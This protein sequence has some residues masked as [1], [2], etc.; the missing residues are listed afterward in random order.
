MRFLARIS[1]TGMAGSALSTRLLLVAVAL[2]G[3]AHIAVLP[4]W[5]GFD[6]FA[7]WSSIQQIADT[8]TV[9]FHGRARISAE[10]EAYAGP[11]PYASVPPFDETGHMTYRSFREAGSPDLDHP[12][13]REYQP[14][15]GRNWQAQHPPL[16]YGILAPIYLLAKDLPLPE[17][18]FILRLATWL[19]AFGGFCLGVLST[20][21]LIPSWGARAVPI[22]AAYPFLVPE[23]FPEMARLG[24]DGLCLLLS[25]AVWMLL[26]KLLSPSRGRWDAAALG[27][28]LGLGL[29]T[30]AFF[31]PISAGVV[32]ILGLIWL[33][34]RTPARRRDILLCG[35]LTAAIGGLWYL[36][37]LLEF[38]GIV[39][40]N[41]FILLDQQGGLISGLER[42]FTV[43]AFARG[44]VSIVVSYTWVGTWS[45]AQLPWTVVVIPATLAAAT[46][47]GWLLRIRRCSP[48]KHL[49]LWLPMF[50]VLPVLAGLLYHMVS[51][52]A[53]FGRSITPGWYLHILAAPIAFA[54]AVG[55]AWPA[56]LR[57][58]AAAAVL[59]GAVGWAGQISLFSG[60]AIKSGH[61]QTYSLAD[62]ACLI[63][64]RQLDVL[65]APWIGAFC[66]AAGIA[67]GLSGLALAQPPRRLGSSVTPATR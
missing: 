7:H 3:M 53:T 66:L 50:L 52:I 55:W 20:E 43:A 38:G 18:L 26:L 28:T 22:M 47:S 21:R 10:V 11:M 54:M 60:C 29:L 8:G 42:N 1:A 12:P 2:V 64:W 46:V 62:A 63:D 9:P 65:G 15:Q 34:E 30:K 39:G 56:L 41:D 48:V 61:V 25:G 67:C 4:P 23:F 13:K 58:L 27:M 33:G 5:E 35:A 31:L 14:G 32:A 49:Y 59:V 40:S 36:R 17:H 37:N 51:S 45:L 16:Y 44:L 57:W 6:E 24:N 19:M